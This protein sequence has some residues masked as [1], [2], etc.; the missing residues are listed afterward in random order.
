MVALGRRRPT[1]LQIDPSR[2]KNNNQNADG[3]KQDSHDNALV[4]F[5]DAE[6]DLAQAGQGQRSEYHHACDGRDRQHRRED[7]KP[8][9][10][11]ADSGN[12]KWDESF[13]W[14]KGQER[15]QTENRGA[16]RSG[17]GAT[18]VAMFIGVLVDVTLN[19]AVPVVMV[20]MVRVVMLMVVTV[21]S[22]LMQMFV[23]VME[24]NVPLSDDLPK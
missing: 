21:I 11:I 22:G 10:A 7:R 8:G 4:F 15:E 20:M 17:M 12:V 24:M 16:I 9:P 3:A 19:V 2:F 18:I 13:A 23:G 6:L 14:R 5:E 1:R